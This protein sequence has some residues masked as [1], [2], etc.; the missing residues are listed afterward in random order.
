MLKWSYF[1][2]ELHLFSHLTII[3]QYIFNVTVDI[4]LFQLSLDCFLKAM[5]NCKF[6]VS[7]FCI[8]QRWLLSIFLTLNV[9]ASILYVQYKDLFINKASFLD[10]YSKKIFEF[11]KKSKLCINKYSIIIIFKTFIFM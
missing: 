2:E 5:F 4:I 6:L 11:K 9:H 3:S 1:I 8:I 10:F 7:V